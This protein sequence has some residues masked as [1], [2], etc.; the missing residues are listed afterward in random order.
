M[1]GCNGLFVLRRYAGTEEL[2]LCC[3][4]T[5]TARKP[6]AAGRVL[7]QNGYDGKHLEPDG[8]VVFVR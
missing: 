3:N 2:T 6:E 1:S 8:F 5:D 7:V 4:Q